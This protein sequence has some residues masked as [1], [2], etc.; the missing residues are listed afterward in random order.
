MASIGTYYHCRV[1]RDVIVGSSFRRRSC[2]GIASSSSSSHRG[3]LTQSTSKLRFFGL[4][5]D[6][7]ISI[8]S[9]LEDQQHQSNYPIAIHHC[10]TSADIST[11]LS[12][13]FRHN[14]TYC[15][16]EPTP[17]ATGKL[18][19]VPLASV[20][21]SQ[22]PPASVS[23]SQPS[24]AP[25]TEVPPSQVPSTAVP[26]APGPSR[27][28]ALACFRP[29]VQVPSASSHP[30]AESCKRYGHRAPTYRVWYEMYLR[31]DVSDEIAGVLLD[32]S[33]NEVEELK[34]CIREKLRLPVRPM[35]LG[36]FDIYNPHNTTSQKH[37][38]FTQELIYKQGD[39]LLRWHALDSRGGILLRSCVV[40]EVSLEFPHLFQ[41]PA[42]IQQFEGEWWPDSYGYYRVVLLHTVG[43]FWSDWLNSVPRR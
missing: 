6:Y 40:F 34:S 3:F 7:Q 22:T 5:I 37:L 2:S 29:P 23:P 10:F 36:A 41:E 25:P 11:F 4:T 16:M 18:L 13:P 17:P 20:P 8:L 31:N 19:N 26:L 14:R 38:P 9:T 27:A 21:P 42:S 28:A 35:I 32:L 15:K 33:P 30:D 24:Q 39:T 1:H 12:R 43:R